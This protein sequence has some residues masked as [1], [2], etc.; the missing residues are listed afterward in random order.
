MMGMAEISVL[1]AD[2]HAILRAGLKMLLDRQA[3]IRVSGEATDGLETINLA[4]DL[5]PDVILLDLTMPGLGGLDALPVLRKTAPDSRILVLTMHED[6]LYLRQ[7][8]KAGAAGYILKEAA[9][10]ELISAI[11]AV[12]RGEVYI[13]PAMTRSLLDGMVPAA[14]SSD[15]SAAADEW[16]SL[17]EREREVLRLV[18][19]GHTAAEAAQQL[20]LSVKTVETYR[21]R[22]MEKLGLRS[23]AALVKY[24]L[25]RGLLDD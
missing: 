6:E 11:R 3:D 8:L 21:S 23:R 20:A 16:D 2:D 14:A 19:L 18:A 12:A 5:K 10:T 9:D 7:A 17:S 1:I 25:G 13:H 15:V 22:G 4:A 24:A